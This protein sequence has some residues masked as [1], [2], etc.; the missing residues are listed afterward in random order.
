MSVDK[1]SIPSALR[2][3]AF[4]QKIITFAKAHI[5]PVLSFES[6]NLLKEFY[7]DLRKNYTPLKSFP[8]TPRT[9]EAAIR[10]SK[11][12]ARIELSSTV[13]VQH[14]AEVIELMLFCFSSC[15]FTS[16]TGNSNK[17]R[18]KSANIRNFMSALESISDKTEFSSNEL[19]DIASQNY[20]NVGNWNE[21]IHIL[22]MNGFIVKT[23]NGLYKRT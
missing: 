1:N 5:H 9:L 23:L 11:A 2:D 17:K 19:K 21:F 14:A 16:T 15:N 20:I 18:T 12:R 10:L 8:I 13:T 7:L 22:N 4:L 6:C 3:I